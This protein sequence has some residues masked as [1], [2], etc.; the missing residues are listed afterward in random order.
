MIRWI[1]MLA[2]LV[3]AAAASGQAPDARGQ[4]DRFADGLES[5]TGTFEQFT[6]DGG[7]R[8]VDESSGSLHFQSPNRFRWDYADPFPQVL[9]ADGEQLWHY[10]ESLDQVTV[11]EQ[12]PAEES[13]L[14]VLTQ[15]ALLDRFYR[16]QPTDDPEVL[17]FIPLGEDTEFEQASLIFEGGMPVILELLDHFGQTTR[18]HL[19]GIERNPELDPELFN[20]VPPE[21]A[22]VLE[23]Y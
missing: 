6:I 9:V 20:F 1:G 15:P 7:G 2:G 5:L 18:L 3:L 4:L 16:I 13:P 17:K 19:G 11:R 23:G 21:G 8:L 12:P 22:D 14:M 10:D